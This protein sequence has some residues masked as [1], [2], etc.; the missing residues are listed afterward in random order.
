MHN[1]AQ[2]KC[3]GKLYG[4]FRRFSK[5]LPDEC[6][7]FK[8]A[9][10][11][12]GPLPRM[13][14]VS[15]MRAPIFWNSHASDVSLLWLLLLS[16]NS[17]ESQRC[18]LI[19]SDLTKEV[20]DVCVCPIAFPYLLTSSYLSTSPKWI[21]WVQRGC[22]DLWREFCNKT[23]SLP[24]ICCPSESFLM[25]RLMYKENASFIFNPCISCLL[26]L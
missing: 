18:S 6:G 25:L 15:Q 11:C 7:I 3:E 16:E 21:R 10:C 13:V 23:C 26:P 14:K 20:H 2:C 19:G 1:Q 8:T 9:F 5:R 12:K 4:K 17:L 22:R 24:Y